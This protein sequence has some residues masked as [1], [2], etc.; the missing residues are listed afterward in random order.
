MPVIYGVLMF[1][2]IWSMKR[3]L[4]KG[5]YWQL[6]QEI[7]VFGLVFTLHGGTMTG[8]MSAMI[9]AWLFGAYISFKGR[10]HV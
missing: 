7:S 8:G 5:R 9:A 4:E 10:K 3:K 6:I 2:G 1:G